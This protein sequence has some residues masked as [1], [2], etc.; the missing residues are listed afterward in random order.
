[1][2]RPGLRGVG[3][4]RKRTPG[5]RIATRFVRGF[6]HPKCGRCGSVLHG[7]ASGSSSE[8]RALKH[9]ERAPSRMYA[10]VLCADCVDS[11]VRYVVRMEAKFSEPELKS[12][13][14]SRDLT[15]EKFLPAGWWGRVQEGSLLWNR[16]E[17]KFSKKKVASVKE[18]APK[19][20]PAKKA[21]KEKPKAHAKKAAKAKAK[22]KKK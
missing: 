7:T 15:L 16:V 4:V 6:S 11:L 13:E 14:F 8:V 17:S 20:K 5:G 2:V 18:A 19:E 21:A 22:A 12:F 10:G 3:K 1:M 9:S